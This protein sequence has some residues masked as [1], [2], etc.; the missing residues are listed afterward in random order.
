M[1]RVMLVVALSAMLFAA[2]GTGS[3][4]AR[5]GGGGGASCSVT[6]APAV[7]GV[8]YTVSVSGLPTNSSI[9]LW[10]SNLHGDLT[11][12]SLGT[13][14]TGS[15]TLTE[16]ASFGGIWSYQFTGPQRSSNTVIYATCSVSVN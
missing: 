6:P 3:A 8:P 16:S 12:T 7:V 1:K 13:T 5:K 14:S 15:F 10:I 4:S 2:V 9:Y 11:M